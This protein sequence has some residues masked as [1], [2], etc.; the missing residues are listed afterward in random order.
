MRKL[1]FLLLLVPVLLHAQGDKPDWCDANNRRLAYPDKTYFT[2]FAMG[3][4]NQGESIGDAVARIENNARADA[5]KHIEVRIE[6]ATLDQMES[7]QNEGRNG[8]DENIQRYFSQKSLA[9]T[10]IQVAN[11]QVVSWHSLDGNEVVAMAYVKKRDF[12]RYHDRQ[13]ESFL[14]K[15]ESALEDIA[16]QEQQGQKI[17]AVSTAEEALLMCPSVEYS[18]RMV[19]LAD[20]EATT[21]DLQMS[22]YTNAVRN[23]ATAITR[24]KHATAFYILCTASLDGKNYPLFDKEVRGVLSNKGC[25]F[26]DNRDDADWI[27]EIDASV[28]NTSHR[29]GMPFFAFIDGTLAIANGATGE[30]VLDDRLSSLE[31]DNHDGIK[32]GDFNAEKAG[33]IAYRNAAQIV[34][35]A[36]LNLIQGHKITIKQY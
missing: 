15:M 32:G 2:G 21:E 33:R 18:Q 11:L 6:S 25:H 19:A 28:V 31:A 22:R 24:L 29:E 20:P 8:L 30:K 14:G 5:S 9:T 23:L 3:Q 13:I 7:L 4:R 34:A 17:K 26:V 12:A 10:S 35:N 27:I 1:V 16:N 36:I